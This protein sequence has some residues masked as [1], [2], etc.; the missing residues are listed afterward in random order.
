MKLTGR[1]TS[2][3]NLVFTIVSVI[4]VNSYNDFVLVNFSVVNWMK[5][6]NLK[7]HTEQLFLVIN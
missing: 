5:F 4:L 7:C 3:G 6:T 1:W 2:F